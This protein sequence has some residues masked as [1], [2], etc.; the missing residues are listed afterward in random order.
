[1]RDQRSSTEQRSSTVV[2]A[3]YTTSARGDPRHGHPPHQRHHRL[4]SHPIASV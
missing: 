1:M 3:F 2:A 4:R